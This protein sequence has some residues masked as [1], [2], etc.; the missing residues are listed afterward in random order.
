MTQQPGEEGGAARGLP[1][2]GLRERPQSLMLTFLGNFVLRRNVSVFS[3]SFIDVFAR[4]GV[5]E[6]AVRST[7]SRMARRGLLSRQR[8]G[9]RVY[10][11]L[12]PHSAQILAD[13]ERRIWETGVINLEKD[14]PWTLLAFSLPESWQRLRHD[15]RSRLVWSGFGPLQSGLWIAP[16]RVDVTATVEELGIDAYARVFHAQLGPPT[17][18][19]QIIADAYDLDELA[20]NYTRFLQRW[21]VPHPL[22]EAPDDLARLLLLMTEWLRN[23]RADP[24]LPLAHLPADWPA[25]RAQ[26]LVE[27]L[28]ATYIGPARRIADEILDVVPADT[29]DEEAD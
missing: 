29:R 4:L 22:P 24:R 3:G 17:E 23:V 14:G 7:L 1:D 2:V 6:Q 5:S 21:D 26:K 8:H 28:Y 18:T 9:R 13:G 20:G 15:L 27:E 25:V 10:F 11:G 19:P 16:S 12:T